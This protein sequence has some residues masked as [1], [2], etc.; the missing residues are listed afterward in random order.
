L[1][2]GSGYTLSWP[3]RAEHRR[4]RVD[5]QAGTF[6]APPPYR[7]HQHFN[8]GDEPARYL[9]VNTPDL[10]KHLGLRFTD[11]VETA[12]PELRGQFEE[13]RADHEQQ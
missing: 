11:Q 8:P 6:F 1:L 12:Q 3:A 13:E 9:S 10:L 7:Y 2:S 4:Q 5:W